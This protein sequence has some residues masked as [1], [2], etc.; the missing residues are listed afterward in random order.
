MLEVGVAGAG[1]AGMGEVLGEPGGVVD[2][3]EQLGERHPRKSSE[4]RIALGGGCG[5]DGIGRERA[6]GEATIGTDLDRSVPGSQGSVEFIEEF[7]EVGVDP[8]GLLGPGASRQFTM[9]AGDAPISGAARS[10]GDDR[11]E[12]LGMGDPALDHRLGG[13]APDQSLLGVDVHHRTEE[14]CGIATPQFFDGVDT[15]GL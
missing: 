8:L 1:P 14:V 9:K 15:G 5:V 3:D 12:L 4:Q 7:V 13:E 10:V 11:I 2:L 6:E